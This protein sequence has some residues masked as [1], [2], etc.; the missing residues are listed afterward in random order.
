MEFLSRE[1]R[2]APAKIVFLCVLC[3]LC[4]EGYA[5]AQV[6]PDPKQMSGIPRQ[7][8]AVPSGSVTVRLI[9]GDLANRILNHPVQLFVNDKPQEGRTDGEGRAQF[10]KLPPGATLKAVAT[11]D[12]ERL[13]SQTFQVPSDGPGIRLMLVATDKE[14]EARQAAEASA[15]AIAGQV[16]LGGDTRIVVEPG[17]ES[18]D[19]FYILEIMNNARAPVNPATPFDFEMPA[20]VTGT[21]LFE[22]STPL[23]RV[24]GNHVR[25]N[26]PFPPGKT[27]L[28]LGAR[29]PVT[30]GS[31]DLTLRLPAMVERVM[32][33]V[34]K[35][36]DIRLT[37]PQ[38]KNQQDFPSGNEVVIAG[39][40]GSVP[41]NQP[42]TLQLTGLPHHSQAPRVIALTLAA[43]VVLAGVV[44][45]WRPAA[46]TV[47][48]D[49][50]KKLLARRERLFHDLVRLEEDHRNG[51]GDPSRYAARRE[52]L[53]AALERVYGALDAG[54]T[55]G[56]GDRTGLAA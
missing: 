1:P 36:G 21:T 17:D 26:G 7:D 35:L 51:R 30:S 44:A 12:G 16:V 55:P 47:A 43:L 14:K 9:R 5:G 50:R 53:V 11:V 10:D 39:V 42:I 24:T 38:I 6:M 31:V 45:A 48:R 4:A 28:Q 13:E 37:S 2:T 34:R 32:V 25:V 23:A 40:G 33:L 8:P 19:I 29:F 15:P 27:T 3:V 52:D 49:E 56:P 54:E 41:A 46:S 20:G 18:L 22:G